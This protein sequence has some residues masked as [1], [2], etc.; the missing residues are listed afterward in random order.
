MW[1]QELFCRFVFNGLKNYL[2]KYTKQDYQRHS[3]YCSS[4][5][6][7]MCTYFSVSQTNTVHPIP[8]AFVARSI[9]LTHKFAPAK[10]E[11]QWSTNKRRNTHAHTCHIH[12]A[13]DSWNIVLFSLKYF[14]PEKLPM[15]ILQIQNTMN[16]ERPNEWMLTTQRHKYQPS[17]SLAVVITVAVCKWNIRYNALSRPTF[18]GKDITSLEVLQLP[19]NV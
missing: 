16:Y 2:V 12:I 8:M 13:R 15:M 6:Y 5:A 17:A 19:D 1:I 14:E 11:L 9:G 7:M 10:T 18:T 3:N 4:V